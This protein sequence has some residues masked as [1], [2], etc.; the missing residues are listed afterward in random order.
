MGWFGDLIRDV[1]RAPVEALEEVLG[2]PAEVVAA[3]RRAGCKTLEE[4]QRF[5]DEME[6]RL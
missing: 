3:A 5:A 1:V 6:Q 2:L 4:I